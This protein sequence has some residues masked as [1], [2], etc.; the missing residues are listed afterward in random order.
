MIMDI[1]HGAHYKQHMN[2]QNDMRY[3]SDFGNHRGYTN[4][5][6]YKANYTDLGNYS[7][8]TN[9][10]NY[11]NYSDFGNYNAYLH[12]AR[13][14]TR[15]EMAVWGGGRCWPAGAR[16]PSPPSST[17]SRSSSS[18]TSGC[19]G[20]S[21][22]EQKSDKEIE[23]LKGDEKVV[24][25]AELKGIT[26]DDMGEEVGQKDIKSLTAR[27]D[28]TNQLQAKKEISEMMDEIQAQRKKISEMT[29]KMKRQLIARDT[30]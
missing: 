19:E 20:P 3:Y 10:G 2:Y 29:D 16:P 5:G 21:H 4:F 28:G 24:N 13:A 27:V 11:G 7:G 22:H 18:Q 25:E 17:S 1:Y 30:G 6:N 14:T 8:Y 12:R 23:E 9:F 15:G 26:S